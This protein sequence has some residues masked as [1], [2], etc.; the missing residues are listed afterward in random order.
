M[1]AMV[2]NIIAL[3]L[4]FNVFASEGVL[5][6]KQRQWAFEGMFGKVDVQ[7]AQRGFQVYKEVCAACHKLDHLYYRNLET[8]IGKNEGQKLHF[9]KIGLGFSAAEV[10]ELASEYSVPDLDDDGQPIE[11]KALP[12]DKF[13]G[14]YPNQKAARSLNNGAYPPDLS[15]I[16]KSRED[17]ANYVHSLL[18]GYQDAPKDMVVSSTHYYNPYFSALLI[19][20]PPPLKE[21]IVSYNDGTKATVDQMA[22]DVVNFLQWAAEPEMMQRKSMGIKVLSYLTITTILLYFAKRRIW[23]N[24]CKNEQE[25]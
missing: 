1:I 13:V 21:G 20:M 18:T 15:L 24:I 5:E 11:R 17:G 22:I 19:S 6:P 12:S 16:I 3:L 8:P 9:E 25:K 4:A 10:K 7:S 2:F 23:S 14:P